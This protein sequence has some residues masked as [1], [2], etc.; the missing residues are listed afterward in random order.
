MDLEKRIATGWV[1]KEA[2]F[3][4]KI[5][6]E[7]YES[8][9]LA[10]TKQ[11]NIKASYDLVYSKTAGEKLI[12]AP[13]QPPYVPYTQ[14]AQIQGHFRKSVGELVFFTGLKPVYHPHDSPTQLTGLEFCG[15][16]LRT[17]GT[18]KQKLVNTITRAIDTYF[19]KEQGK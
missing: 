4:R 19:R 18:D 11:M 10:I 1:H 8:M 13:Q 12:S 5:A 16:Q 3:P 17:S 14:G 2:R 15:I 7:E 6:L 9:I